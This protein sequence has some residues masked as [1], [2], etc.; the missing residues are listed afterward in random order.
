MIHERLKHFYLKHLNLFN[1]ISEIEIFNFVVMMKTIMN[2]YELSIVDWNKRSLNWYEM[3]NF[4]YQST[5]KKHTIHINDYVKLS[6]DELIQMYHIY[7]HAFD[8]E[9]LRRV[10]VW[11]CLFE[12]SSYQN[13]IFQLKIY[14]LNKIKK[15]IVFLIFILNEK[16][17]LISI[18]RKLNDSSFLKTDQKTDFLY[19]NWIVNFLWIEINFRQHFLLSWKTIR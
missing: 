7:T 8:Y 6:T 5:E 15:N 16:T 3:C 11:I 12:N 13:E 14:K 17:Y 2:F 9:N 1:K 19:C 10:F 4:I 18:V